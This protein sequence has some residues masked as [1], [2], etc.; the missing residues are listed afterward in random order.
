MKRSNSPCGCLCLDIIVYS[1]SW[2]RRKGSTNCAQATCSSRTTA[3]H[4]RISSGE[5]QVQQSLVTV[6]F[7]RPVLKMTRSGN[8]RGTA[9]ELLLF[10]LPFYAVGL[11]KRLEN[12]LDRPAHLLCIGGN[13]KR[14]DTADGLRA[15]L[16]VA[17]GQA[18]GGGLRIHVP[19]RSRRWLNSDNTHVHA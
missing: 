16:I 6:E 8:E 1:R 9:G 13:R 19:W 15:I 17:F 4:P 2:R 11:Q 7:A 10:G 14:V 5:K 3:D 12:G 18:G